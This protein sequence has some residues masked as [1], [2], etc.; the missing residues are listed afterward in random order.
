MRVFLDTEFTGLHQGTTLISIGLIAEDGRA[1]YAEL[2]DYD[3]SQVDEWIQVNVIDNLTGNGGLSGFDVFA[4]GDSW[5]VKRALDSWF[6]TLDE[7]EIWGDC[8]AYDWVLFHQLFGHAFNIPGNVYYIP[9]D[10]STLFKIAGVDPDINREEYA[11]LTGEGEC[12][13]N[14]LWDAKVIKA[15]YDKVMAGRK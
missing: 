2:T 15:C 8:L 9:F 1:F 14:A 12:K 7:V 11:G 10:L 13:H 6:A 4:C 5:H 3:R